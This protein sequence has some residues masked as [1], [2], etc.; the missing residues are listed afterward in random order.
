MAIRFFADQITNEDAI[1]DAHE[2]AH[3][4]TMRISPGDEVEF[5]DGRG[6]AFSGIL[7]SIQKSE[8]RVKIHHRARCK[9]L[10]TPTQ[11]RIW[12][13]MANARWTRESVLIEKGVE[14]GIHGL[15]TFPGQHSQR[16]EPNTLKIHLTMRKALKQCGGTILPEHLFLPRLEQEMLHLVPEGAWIMLDPEAEQSLKTY[17]KDPQDAIILWVG[18]EGGFSAFEK[19]LLIDHHA[20]AYRLGKRILRLET[21]A[22]IGIAMLTI[23]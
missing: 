15:I 8:A 22:I 23:E 17:K 1:F 16:K 3:L 21:A 12:L 20:I 6:F 4:K 19:Q 14:L 13:A 2:V 9:D 5:T 11:T 10:E 7:Q 18:P